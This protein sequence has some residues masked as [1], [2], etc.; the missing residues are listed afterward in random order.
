MIDQLGLPGIASGSGKR[1]QA[2]GAAWETAIEQ[3]AA[4]GGIKLVKI[5]APLQIVAQAPAR[6]GRKADPRLVLARLE[7][8]MAPD[9]LG[10]CRGGAVAFEAKT[11][12]PT[13]HPTSWKLDDRLKGH[14][15]EALAS[16]AAQGAVAA[17][18]LRRQ[19]GWT[20][21]TKTKPPK[22]LRAAEYVVP[23]PQGDPRPERV[24]VPWP[25]LEPW[26]VPAGRGWWEAIVDW[27]SYC[28][29]GWGAL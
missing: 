7:K 23:W 11:A 9:W 10:V 1:S 25:D 3:G 14:Q 8:A 24:S 28:A 12:S 26:K 6:K 27:E 4:F 17:V 18:L 13:G 5:P 22:L 15:G 20:K 2:A 21:G 16:W 19:P 29:A